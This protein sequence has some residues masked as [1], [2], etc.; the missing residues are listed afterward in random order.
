MNLSWGFG[1]KAVIGRLLDQT[2]TGCRYRSL[3]TLSYNKRHTG[4]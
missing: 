3:A 2:Q 4:I 1:R